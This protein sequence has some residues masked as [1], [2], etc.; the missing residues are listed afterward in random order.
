MYKNF[1][2]SIE[3]GNVVRHVCDNRKCCNPLHLLQG[4]QLENIQD[5]IERNRM[6]HKIPEKTILEMAKYWKAGYSQRKIAKLFGH[7]QAS[8]SK[9]FKRLGI[10]KV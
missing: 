2:G 7:E 8:I 10:R 3:K 1:Y 6:P 5:M 4:T 9:C